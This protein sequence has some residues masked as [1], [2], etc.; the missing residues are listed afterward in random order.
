MKN[1]IDDLR[2]HL[3]ETIE[4]LKDGDQR[5]DVAKARAVSD[6]AGRLIDTAKV[7]VEFL[8]AHDGMV[9]TGF[10]PEAEVKPIGQVGKVTA[11]RQ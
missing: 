1:K 2:N 7:E 6:L 9:P 5:M 11:I 10:M 8:K 4:M 3:F